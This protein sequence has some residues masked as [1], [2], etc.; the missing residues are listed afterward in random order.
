MMSG[1][2][3]QSSQSKA[4]GPRGRVKVKSGC[5]TCK[6]RKVKCDEGRPCCKRC[7]GTGRICDGYGIWGG[8]GNGYGQRRTGPKD[9]NTDPPPKLAVTISPTVLVDDDQGY[10]EWF[11]YRTALKLPGAFVSAFWDTLVL[12]ASSSEPAV[13][14]AALALSA[15]HKKEVVG[16]LGHGKEKSSSDGDET[17]ALRQYSKAITRLQA[18]FLANNKASVRVAL[19]TCAIFICLEYIRGHY[20]TGHIHLLNGLKLLR[21]LQFYTASSPSHDASSGSPRLDSVD[22]CLLETFSR[23]YTQ[24][25]MLEQSLPRV[26]AFLDTTVSKPLGL[27]FLSTQQAKLQ[28]QQVLNGVTH[29]SEQFCPTTNRQEEAATTI[30]PPE[31]VKVQIRIKDEL[32]VWLETYKASHARLQLDP[33][34]ADAYAYRLLLIHYTLIQI[35]AATCLP[36]ASGESRFDAHNTDFAVIIARTI[37]FFQFL[38]SRS[39][40]SASML[41]PPPDSTQGSRSPYTSELGCIPPLYYTAIKCRVHRVRLHA[42][43][44]LENSPHREGIWDAMLAARI[45]RQVMQLEEE[46]VYDDP[47]MFH[48]DFPLSSTPGEEHLSMPTIPEVYRIQDVQVVLPDDPMENVV[49]KCRRRRYD[50]SFE[51]LV[52][53]FEVVSQSWMKG[54]GV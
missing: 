44:L 13:L 36:Q 18:P 40:G 28:L 54:R 41:D 14:H 46:D 43:R 1:R 29:L 19:I 33:T 45:A 48:D 42:I 51:T 38:S 6:I 34:S 53:E 27:T 7:I 47:N 4:K 10:F 15:T 9:S 31:L 20:R 16:I 52:R 21:E 17:F 8:G 22:E 3:A 11:R 50:G 37:D 23:L 32:R 2:C 39:T 35:M 26:A 30:C 49:L 5:S 12:Q 24:A 25:K